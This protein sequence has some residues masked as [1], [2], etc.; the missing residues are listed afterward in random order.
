MA[1]ISCRLYA[2]ATTLSK[3]SVR[4]GIK[5]TP[6][7]IGYPISSARMFS[8][9]NGKITDIE[10]EDMICERL[11]RNC[12]LDKVTALPSNS[13]IDSGLN[14]LPQKRSFFSKI[15]KSFYTAS[16]ILTLKKEKPHLS[17]VFEIYE[18]NKKILERVGR[19][20]GSVKDYFNLFDYENKW[21]YPKIVLALYKE[22]LGQVEK[23][24]SLDEREKEILKEK[25]I[26]L[27]TCLECIQIGLFIHKAVESF[28][29]LLLK[30]T[31][32]QIPHLLRRT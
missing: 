3:V 11:M 5:M 16:K 9:A 6:S 18:I 8:T 15:F 20:P 10:R 28:L 22:V 25:A 17:E 7:R 21:I 26:I 2:V 4:K 30:F 32:L 19:I 13:T 31:T 14:A 27:A 24:N 12:S 1:Q 29:Y 23:I